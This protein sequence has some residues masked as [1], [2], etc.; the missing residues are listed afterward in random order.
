[1]AI[2]GSLVTTASARTDDFSRGMRRM[3]EDLAQTTQ[4][5]TLA[6][7]SFSQLAA[8][9]TAAAAAALS[10]GALKSGIESIVRTGLDLERLRNSFTAITGTAERSRQEFGFVRDTANRL[11]LDIQS[12]GDSYRSLLAATRGTQ[13]EGQATR[14]LFTSLTNASRAYGLSTDQTG[15]AL[16]AFQQIISKGKVSQEELRGQL[17]EALPGASQIAARAFGVT[18]QELDK[19]VEKGVDAVTFVRRFTEQL[20]KE[21]PTA[22]QTA[23]SGIR[24]LGNEIL[25]LKDDI[26]NSGVIA[27][28]DR[29]ATRGADLL[30]GRREGNAE[31][32]ARVARESSR[33]TGGT[34]IQSAD[35]DNISRQIVQA[36]ERL[37]DAQ[38]RRLDP[39]TV[40]FLRAELE[41]L[42]AIQTEVGKTV[43]TREQENAQILERGKL[44]TEI[45]PQF[46]AEQAAQRK[47]AEKDAADAAIAATGRVDEFRIAQE[48][49]AEKEEEARKAEAD[50]AKQTIATYDQ[51]T[52]SQQAF[53]GGLRDELDTLKLSEDA[54]AR[55]RILRSA[56]TETQR[57]L[58]NAIQDEITA[59][60]EAQSIP[61]VAFPNDTMSSS[62]EKIRRDNTKEVTRDLRRDLRD[63]QRNI[64]EFAD[65]FTEAILS[66]TEIGK[67][68][69]KDFVDSALRDLQRLLFR[70]FLAPSLNELLL[71]GIGS[72][73]GLFG[74]AVAGTAAQTAG[75]IQG[76]GSFPSGGFAFGERASG[77]PVMGP[78]F[79]TVG[80]QGPEVLAVGRGQAGYVYPNGQGPGGA[81]V[82][83]TIVT[84]DVS[85]FRRSQGEVA[86]RLASAVRLGLAST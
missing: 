76:S 11:G 68:G 58:A 16:L 50:N 48:L 17:G 5:S 32:Q 27:F 60:K 53:L 45:G 56:L 35:L 43:V 26:A 23:G 41:A 14:E 54:L 49:A 63:S 74:G 8:G 65:Y 62:L 4:A 10:L 19:L 20:N 80:E 2:A 21:A 42:R 44:L 77:G 79:Y 40:Q 75:A 73:A 46:E 38:R 81:T 22:A 33:A 70:Q 15:R 9:V 86:Q 85:S 69:F 55:Q 67:R 34:G 66:A 61:G 31:E 51:L 30:K 36:E 57:G 25:L 18:T 39:S 28:L 24:R 12:L 37:A 84:Q 83:V 82:N 1:M 47:Q 29:L 71:K 64:Q 52:T 6:Q 72:L 7:V 59:I 3:R 78:G 13:L